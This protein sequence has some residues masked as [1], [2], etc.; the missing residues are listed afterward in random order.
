MTIPVACSHC[1]AAIDF[2]ETEKGIAVTNV[3]KCGCK[4][5]C[6]V[7]TRECYIQER[8][9]GGKPALAEFRAWIEWLRGVAT[10]HR[11]DGRGVDAMRLDNCAD[12][13]DRL[14]KKSER[15]A[16]RLADWEETQRSIMD[17]PCRGDEVHCT[18][19][20]VL[21]TE[22]TR[23]REKVRDAR[24]C[25]RWYF[26]RSGTFAAK[27]ALRRGWKWLGQI[28][29]YGPLSNIAEAAKEE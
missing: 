3:Y 14:L 23:L 18:C 10:L 19:V 5:D 28:T 22:I 24:E 7:R 29:D 20:P 16:V 2:T 6:S 25:A 12:E 17:E 27:S 9:E 21:R 13:I 26:D 1:G 8:A 4:S 11:E 15:L